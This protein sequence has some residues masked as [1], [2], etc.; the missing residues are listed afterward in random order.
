M[1]NGRWNPGFTVIVSVFSG[2]VL[3]AIIMIAIY[4]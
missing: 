2:L 4:A 3:W 1:T